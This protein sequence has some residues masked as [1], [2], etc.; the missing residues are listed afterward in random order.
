MLIKEQDEVI[1]MLERIRDQKQ[2]VY[3]HLVQLKPINFHREQLARFSE[4]DSI[5]SGPSRDQQTR[6]EIDST[7]SSPHD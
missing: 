7:A 5:T 3:S 2:Y 1:A 6:M 4:H